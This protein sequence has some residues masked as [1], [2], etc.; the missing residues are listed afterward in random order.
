M[1][2]EC[3][4]DRADHHQ[5]TEQKTFVV[6]ERGHHLGDATLDIA[7]RDHRGGD[8]LLDDL[9]AVPLVAA[10]LPGG[11]QRVADGV[12]VHGRAA[13][14]VAQRVVGR[15]GL[16]LFHDFPDPLIDI[17]IGV[18]GGL[19]HHA[20]ATQQEVFVP[21]VFT[22]FEKLGVDNLTRR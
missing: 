6:A 4:G 17:G 16:A 21:G 18:T 22:D 3:G 5:E 8:F 19:G 13:Q 14:D 10:I 7:E 20:G 9:E 12:L 15:L 2:G 1:S 11:L